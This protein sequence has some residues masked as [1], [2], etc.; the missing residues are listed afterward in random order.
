M[1]KI[2]SLCFGSMILLSVLCSCKKQEEHDKIKTEWSGEIATIPLQLGG[3]FRTE[4]SPLPMGRQ[5]NNARTVPDSVIY[6]I[7][8]RFANNNKPFAQ[9]L[10]TSLDT[11]RVIIP[12]GVAYTLKVVAIKKGSSLGLNADIDYLGRRWI[13]GPFYKLLLNKFTVDS[14]GQDPLSDNF[15]RS[16]SYC[17]V[18]T[19]DSTYD[20]AGKYS[21]LDSYYGQYEG[22]PTDWFLN[23]ITVSL[24]RITFGIR[25]QLENFNEGTLQVDLGGYTIERTFPVNDLNG[26]LFT[27]MSEDYLTSDYLDR[28]LKLRLIWTSA[29]YGT[30]V[31]DYAYVNPKRNTLTTVHVTA[32]GSGIP[33]HITVSENDWESNST[34]NIR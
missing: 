16:L 8:V 7:D 33:L 28:D 20:Y 12:K 30:K 2:T 1:K 29:K 13:G 31:L 32:P 23:R 11:V 19:S 24:K 15:M 4:V 25:F 5:Q 34:V 10:F 14:L 17:T 9:G 22:N 18:A 27:Y 26:R 6:G 21:E 3:D